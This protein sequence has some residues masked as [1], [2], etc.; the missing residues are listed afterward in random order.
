MNIFP[1]LS[2]ATDFY[3]SIF[4]LIQTRTCPFVYIIVKYMYLI[5][6]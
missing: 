4:P 5:D 3:A 6:R 2:D 1:N